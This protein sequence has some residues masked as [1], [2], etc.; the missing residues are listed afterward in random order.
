MNLTNWLI[1]GGFATTFAVFVTGYIRIRTLSTSINQAEANVEQTGA[2][3]EVTLSEA[4]MQWVREARERAEE[5]EARAAMAEKR[6]SEAEGRALETS[7]RS[8]QLEAKIAILATHI[9]NLE[10]II[11]SLGHKPPRLDLSA[12]LPFAMGVEPKHT[13]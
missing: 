13:D 10:A 3:T 6:A 1:G 7:R 2:N 9:F 4:A 8:I 11:E 12:M 5:V